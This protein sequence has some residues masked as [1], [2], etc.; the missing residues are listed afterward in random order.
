[1]NLKI[2]RKIMFWLSA[3]VKVLVVI[4]IIYKLIPF[5]FEKEGNDSRKVETNA[6]F[7]KKNKSGSDKNSFVKDFVK[8]SIS[9]FSETTKE[10]NKAIEINETLR[11]KG[12]ILQRAYFTI[13]KCNSCKSTLTGKDGKTIA[14]IP[15]MMFNS[16]K[17]YDFFVFAMDTLV[18]HKSMRFSDLQFNKY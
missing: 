8:D 18:Y 11:Y 16:Y 7:N 13:E 1:M 10:V 2:E 17:E 9:T 4:L 6:L 3:I 5:V 15:K 14:Y 12:R